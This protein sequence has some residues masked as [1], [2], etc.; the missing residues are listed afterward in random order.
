[1]KKARALYQLQV[2][3][4]DIEQ[5]SRRLKEVESQLQETDE[6]RAARAAAEKAE[7]QLKEDR[8]LLHRLELENQ[9]LQG[10]IVEEERRLYGGRIT[11]PKELRSLEDKIKNLKARRSRL[12]DD[13]LE[14]MMAVEADE[15]VLTESQAA[16]ARV[17]AAWQTS[18]ASLIT[19]RN[20]LKTG[21]ARQSGERDALRAAIPPK[22]LGV[23]DNLY[24]RKGG[25]SVARVNV[26]TCGAC[27]VSVSARQM[28]AIADG[29]ELV[30]CSA[31]ER[32]L[33][34]DR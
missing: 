5:K 24:G 14:T 1:M 34:A 8:A 6:L 21:L 30:P 22:D 7:K 15:V 16:L 32:I 3:D 31:C 2:L 26:G 17:D 11:I 20:Q 28:Q 25:R 18:Q 4:T 13:V 9:S 27:G 12:E 10:D 29:E 19:E 33:Y 23:Y